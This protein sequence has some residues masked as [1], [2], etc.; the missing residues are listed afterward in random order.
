MFGI[1]RNHEDNLKKL[2]PI[3]FNLWTVDYAIGFWIGAKK[4]GTPWGLHFLFG[5]I[6]NFQ[7]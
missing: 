6:N 5:I 2:G 3:Y 7:D 4:N 1:N